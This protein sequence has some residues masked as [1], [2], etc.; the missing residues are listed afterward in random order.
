MH[1]SEFGSC[2]SRR[3]KFLTFHRYYEV[4]CLFLSIYACDDPLTLQKH[5]QDHQNFS[6]QR[7][8]RYYCDLIQRRNSL[9]CTMNQ[10][11][12]QLYMEQNGFF[13]LSSFASSNILVFDSK[14]DIILLIV[15][16]KM[17]S[18]SEFS[19]EH[20]NDFACGYKEPNFFKIK[21]QMIVIVK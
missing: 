10:E 2:F 7:N 8:Y 12:S 3:K 11:W 21:I 5:F 1:K 18:E 15:L 14:W 4:L 6:Y 17:S 9:F 16:L 19:N 20:R 13:S